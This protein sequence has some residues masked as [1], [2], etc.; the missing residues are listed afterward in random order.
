MLMAEA[1]AVFEKQ[2]LKLSEGI[3]RLLRFLVE[4]PD[5][6]KPVLLGQAYGRSERTLA[7]A[8]LERA[9]AK[10]G[11]AVKLLHSVARELEN[12]RNAEAHGHRIAAKKRRPQPPPE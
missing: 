6:T 4:A 9:L 2:G 7:L 12:E 5:E 8:V 10:N 1:E 11:M 3:T